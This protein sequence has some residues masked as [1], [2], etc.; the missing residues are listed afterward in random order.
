MS[1]L[2]H[3]IYES[4]FLKRIINNSSFKEFLNQNNLSLNQIEKGY[5]FLI[6][7]SINNVIL[8]I[9]YLIPDEL[10]ER[11]VWGWNTTTT[12]FTKQIKTK[13]KD[14]E[15]I[16]GL[17]S[18]KSKI[19]NKRMGVSKEDISPLFDKLLVKIQEIKT[20]YLKNTKFK[21]NKKLS[22][23]NM[24]LFYIANS[25]PY[26]NGDINVE[27]NK[28]EYYSP[29]DYHYHLMPTSDESKYLFSNQ[30]ISS[31]KLKYI[32]G[33]AITLSFIFIKKI[34]NKL[35][36]KFKSSNSW[37][38]IHQMGCKIRDDIIKSYNINVTKNIYEVTYGVQYKKII[39]VIKKINDLKNLLRDREILLQ[40]IDYIN[41]SSVRH[42]YDETFPILFRLVLSHI[43]QKEKID[44]I[45]L[46]YKKPNGDFSHSYLI[47][48]FHG[49]GL[50]NGSYWLLFKDT[51][52]SNEGGY[53]SDGKMQ[54]DILLEK[55]P[56]AF[57]YSEYSIEP[58]LFQRYLQQY[59]RNYA[60]KIYLENSLKDSKS[61]LNELLHY[62][63]N[64]KR[65]KNKIIFSDWSHEF[66]DTEIDSIIVTN[67]EILITQSKTSFS[68]VTKI[69][70]HFE[71]VLKYLPKYA[72][73]KK[74]P[75]KDKQI[76]K[77]LFFFNKP[78]YDN[79]KI[80]MLRKNK[81]KLRTVNEMVDEGLID[82][83]LFEKLQRIMN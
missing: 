23:D 14:V 20:H 15:Y 26:L 58:R 61:M 64:S 59:C 48:I 51:G 43:P 66:D 33:Y 17:E 32:Q 47:Y 55:F 18:F 67:S 42:P 57:N 5:L 3:L 13:S 52:L 34:D 6:E 71:K 39:K 37:D 50:S 28:S 46:K 2:D 12:D 11:I 72:I 75:I 68:K 10:S 31:H 83:I 40:N 27:T 78:I 8:A 69:I 53:R 74:F 76:I 29:A 21:E 79:E 62:Y 77:E 80:E 81:I 70:N 1:W 60:K 73:Q 4:T 63:I 45:E 41:E 44:L 25:K 65:Y 35:F 30:E 38:D 36:E 24:F 54:M 7:I 19:Q 9:E 22:K 56:D 82:K 49:G 16:K